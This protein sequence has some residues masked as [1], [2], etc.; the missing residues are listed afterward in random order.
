VSARLIVVGALGRRTGRWQL[1]SHADRTA[2]RAHVPVLVVREAEPFERWLDKTRPLRIVLGVDAS[3]SSE[4]AGRWISQLSAFGP[5]EV[6][7]AHLYWPPEEFHRLG[8][9]GVRS[10]VDPDAE[11]TKTLEQ[12]YSARFAGLSSS[13]KVRYRIEPHLGRIGDALAAVATEE[14]ADLVVVGSHDR[15]AFARVWEGSV[16]RQAVK[17]AH[18]S[19][20]CI[21]AVVERQ[22][23]KT[24]SV[25]SVLCA[26]DF[27]TL[28]N[29]A[30]PLAY[31]VVD[32]G[33]TVHL[34]HIVKTAHDPFDAYDIFTPLPG[35]AFSEAQATARTRLAE[36]IPKDAAAANISTDIHVLQSTEPATAICQAAER[37]GADIICLGTHGRSGL[38]KAVLG[39]VAQEVL[40]HTRRP[41]LLA[42]AQR[43]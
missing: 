33:G 37:I 29:G 14:K 24:P 12:D 28:G 27:S 40:T 35:K 32:P 5:C 11:I 4:A 30:I 25:R 6:V 8:L 43:E 42:R 7:L 23:Q 41:V 19:V 17:S 1:G 31:S 39:S 3:L 36:L 20:A 26:T 34:V 16:T 38:P 18:C 21:P 15:S 2:Q 9:G 10:Y 22:T 13:A